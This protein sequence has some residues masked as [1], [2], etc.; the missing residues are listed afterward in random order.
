MPIRYEDQIVGVI[1][2]ESHRLH[3]FDEDAVRFI[4]ALADQA[5]IAIGNAQ[6]YEAQVVQGEQLLRRASQLSQ[7]LEIS[8]ALIGEQPLEEVLDQIVHAVVDTAGFNTAA[9]RID[10]RPTSP[11]SW[12]WS[13]AAGM[14]LPEYLRLRARRR[15]LP[16][17]QEVMQPEFRLGRA[18]YMPAGTW[19]QTLM[20]HLYHRAA[21]RRRRPGAEWHPEDLL[22]LP[23]LSTTGEF[24]GTC[25]WTARWT[26]PAHPQRDRNAGDLRQP[27]RPRHRKRATVPALSSSASPR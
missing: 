27:G 8:N 5:A 13:A 25:R 6:N 22:F 14:P 7:V 2:L 9:L 18:Y 24:L 10:R 26:A 12:S 19:G 15:T 17:V 21:A 16:D 11:I 20:A 3:G 1:N 23:L 4:E